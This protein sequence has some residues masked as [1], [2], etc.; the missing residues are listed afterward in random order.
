MGK[1]P[2]YSNKRKQL[3]RQLI[4]A[5]F[6]GGELNQFCTDHFPEVYQRFTSELTQDEKIAQLIEYCAH[7]G[8]LGNLVTHLEATKPE[9]YRAFVNQVQQTNGKPVQTPLTSPE[10]GSLAPHKSSEIVRN[11]E[12]LL[13]Q[14]LVGRYQI[15][16]ILDRGGIGVVFKAYDTHLELNVAIKIIDLTQV[17]LPAMRERVRQEV[18]T[19]MKL[20]HPGIVQ[21][22]DF[23]QV[24]SLLYIIMEFIPGYDLQKVRDLFRGV[25][26][27]VT[28]P[29]VL[30]LVCQICLTVDYMHQHR[31]LHPG[32]KPENIMLKPTQSSNDLA[33]QPVLINLGLLRPHREM[34][35]SQHKMST[36]RLTYTVSPELLLGHTTD[37]RSD[38]YTLGLILYNLVVGQPPF[39]PKDLAEAIRM[40]VQE[41]PVRPRAIDP[42]IPRAVEEIILKAL[43]KDPSERYITARAM[44][45]ALS[46]YLDSTSLPAPE[47]LTRVSLSLA[48][49]S[50]MV[51]PGETLTTTLSL[52]N[53]GTADH[54]A[55]ISLAGIPEEWFSISPSALTI[56]PGETRKVEL[57]IQPPR[58][59]DSRAGRHP[60]TIR[61]INQQ[62]RD[63]VDEIKQVLT[64]APYFQFASSLWPQEIS[65]GQVTQVSV[66]NQG[67][68]IETFTVEPK[69]EQ[70]LA[71][72]PHQRMQLKLS[73]GESET[74]D[75]QVAPSR[76]FW[77]ADS[78]TQTFSLLVTSPDGQ[79]AIHSGQ[80]T[81]HGSVTPRW[82]YGAIL[83]I[84]L[85]LVVVLAFYPIVSPPPGAAT[86]TA[87]RATSQAIS[88]QA[89]LD[90][91]TSQVVNN[92]TATVLAGTAQ[93]QQTREAAVQAAT[94]TVTWLDRDDDRDGLTNG[95]E[96]E[97]GTDPND[98]DSDGDGLFDGAEVNEFGTN[99]FNQDT[100]FDGLPDDEEIRLNLNASGRD[101]D[102]D[103]TPDSVDEDPGR[104]PTP[105][106]TITPNPTTQVPVVRFDNPA[107]TV[108]ERQ[109]TAIITVILD[110]PVD[111]PVSVEYETLDNTAAGGIDYTRSTGTLV[112]DPNQTVQRFTVLINN[113]TL[114]EPDETVLLRLQNPQG[115]NLGF[116]SQT[117]L[118]ILDDDDENGD[119]SGD[120]GTVQIRF[121]ERAPLFGLPTYEVQEN[122]GRAIIEV[123][124]S[125][126]VP[127]QIQVDYTIGDNTAT[128]GQDYEQTGGTLVFNPGQ[129]RKTFD[130]RI[131]EDNLVEGEEIANLSLNNAVG[132]SIATRRARL[133]ILDND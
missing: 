12:E 60:L 32:T 119:G 15:Q 50:L 57:S 26:R 30:Q 85:V 89:T 16:E 66:E 55:H 74:V 37:I 61:A 121:S 52:H 126:S 95:D 20:D 72:K 91:A 22:Y 122:Q 45:Q 73:P 58:S 31:V 27:R 80:V 94:A 125:E 18:R 116:N 7:R 70:S 124:L 9:A 106:A 115:A 87:Q 110:R 131:I 84:V 105:T 44:A 127:R 46:A 130:V 62:H 69:P 99:P 2:K 17:K 123:I 41:P 63:Q 75:Y 43:A 88:Q 53:D 102:L 92:Q 39:E 49:T 103:G 42:S 3:L 23:G 78:S 129:Q 108:D 5:I 36:R 54:H 6:N 38:V 33:W 59:P 4:E 35:L 8:R 90:R 48:A 128:S 82:L 83:A 77:V 56:P 107:Y 100:D 98:R 93:V 104:L 109:Q 118:T 24:D 111:R 71:F 11:P 65:T 79:T 120:N 76:R 13:D 132:A 1:T 10:P 34:L 25:E 47:A 133:V 96:L 19:A 97:I 112:F 51:S 64:V 14:S 117:T 21:V 40:H 86:A 29:Q 68:T 113:D 67:N 101:T 81:S 28:L 114:S